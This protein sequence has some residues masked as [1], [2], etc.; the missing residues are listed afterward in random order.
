MDEIAKQSMEAL[1]LSKD[2][3]PQQPPPSSAGSAISLTVDVVESIH[4]FLRFQ[5]TRAETRITKEAYYTG[6]PGSL[7]GYRTGP[8]QPIRR[9]LGFGSTADKALAMARESI[10]ASKR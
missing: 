4:P 8:R 3:Q 10:G 6:N 7:A 2:P 9:L 1:G 5:V